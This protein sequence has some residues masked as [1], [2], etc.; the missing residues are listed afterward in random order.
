M[1]DPNP[2]LVSNRE[3]SLRA[4]A[5]LR[6]TRDMAGTLQWLAAFESGHDRALAAEA[7][8]DELART[9][10]AGAL[11]VAGH[12][13]V[14]DGDG[15]RE[16]LVQLWTEE[17]PGEATDWVMRQPA[18]PG[19]DRLAARIAYVRAQTDP[20]EATALAKTYIDGAQVK[21]DT[22]IAV[23]RQW[24]LRDPA[25]A[26]AQ[27]NELTDLGMRLRALHEI[28]MSRRQLAAY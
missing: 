28:E 12:F 27:A 24:A 21:Q 11:E 10:P 15:R 8:V 2:A 7:V 6:A 22:L 16:Y 25:A 19:R 26:T 17:S 5:R 14:G 20:A 18:G 1:T 4:E 3:E 13:Q 23:L 9:D